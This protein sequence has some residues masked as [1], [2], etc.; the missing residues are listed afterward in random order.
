MVRIQHSPDFIKDLHTL[1]LENP[2]IV[3]EV[4]ERITWFRKKPYDN[5]LRNHALR[6]KLS[7]FWAFSITSDI[8]IVYLWLGKNR[9]RFLGIGGHSKV[10]KKQS[11]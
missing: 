10:Y 3:K 11:H 1:V 6:G 7:G 8:R 9:A 4:N 2:E 5:R